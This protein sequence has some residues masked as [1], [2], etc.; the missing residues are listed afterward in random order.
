MKVDC[1]ASWGQ[2]GG[3]MNKPDTCKPCPLYGDGK[4]FVPGRIPAGASTLIFGQN[5]GEDEEK[6]GR[7]LVGA[8][9][10]LLDDQFLPYT[11]LDTDDVGRDNVIR[12]RWQEPGKKVKTNKMPPADILWK[13]RECCKQ[14]DPDV[15][16]F[17]LV[18]LMGQ[19]ALS[20]FYPGLKQHEWAGH[21]LPEKEQP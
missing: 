13:A 19:V 9:G 15:E 6:Q 17:D 3:I 2:M 5:P 12:C 21:L 4:G 7:P 20:A 10:K 16:A 1:R 11:G 14:Y 18:I 8:T